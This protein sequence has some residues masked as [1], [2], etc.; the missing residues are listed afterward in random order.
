MLPVSPGW[1]DCGPQVDCLAS[2]IIGSGGGA[3]VAR[4]DGRSLVGVGTIN[5]ESRNQTG[6]WNPLQRSI[7]IGDELA[8]IGLD[9]IKFSEPHRPHRPRQRQLGR[10]RPVRLLLVHGGLSA[11]DL[12]LCHR[13]RRI[14]PGSVTQTS[15]PTEGRELHRASRRRVSSAPRSGQTCLGARWCWREGPCWA[16]CA[17]CVLTRPAASGRASSRHF[18][19]SAGKSWRTVVRPGP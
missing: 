14:S 17:R 8:T 3:V 6:C 11:P 10:P 9:Q 13:H 16:G 12:G 4:L 2:E 15:S 5:H 7:A 19:A 1:G 18:A